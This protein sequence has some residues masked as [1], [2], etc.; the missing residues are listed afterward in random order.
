MNESAETGN[1][2]ATA[3]AAKRKSALGPCETR[4]CA[5]RVAVKGACFCRGCGKRYVEELRSTK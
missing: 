1:V 5:K 2:R 3:A 4:G